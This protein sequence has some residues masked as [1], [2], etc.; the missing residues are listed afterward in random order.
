AVR[1]TARPATSQEASAERQRR[2][3]FLTD[4]VHA[5]FDAG[6]PVASGT[7]AGMVGTYHGYATLR[8][9]ELLVQAGLTPMQAIT[10]ATLVSARA[11]GVE[12]DRGTIE[13][14]KAADLVLVEGRP[15]ERIADLI[16]TRRVFVAG[17]E[18]DPVSLRA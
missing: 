9:L 1:E 14:G 18:Y 16:Q 17:V 11:M 2:W 6:I 4:N 5:L 8:E 12:R 13:A 10:A 15:D 7:D 3:R